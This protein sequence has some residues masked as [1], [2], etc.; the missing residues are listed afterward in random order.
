MH[1]AQKNDPHANPQEASSIYECKGPATIS[2]LTQKDLSKE[3]WDAVRRLQILDTNKNRRGLV[4]I[5]FWV[6]GGVLSN[7]TTNFALLAVSELSMGCALMGLSVF[8]HEASH[9]L[10]FP[11]PS[12]NR[13]VGFL[14]GLPALI[15]I[16][17]YRSLHLAHHAFE[18]TSMDPDD[19]EQ[20][21]KQSIP[22]AFFYYFFMVIGTYLYIPHVA[23]R[24]YVRARATLRINI[25]TEYAAIIV[26]IGM[27]LSFVP[28]AA[29]LRL[30]LIPLIIASQ[31]TNIRGIAEH[32]LTTGG[33]P[34]TASRTVLSNKVV[35]FFFCNLNYHLEH[36]LFPGVP[37]YNL[38]A[39]HA[40]LREEYKL[41]GSTVYRSYTEFFRDF[42]KTSQKG[43][44]PNVRL[45]P[46]H[47]REEICS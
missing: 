23:A 17:A 8:M 43:I 40:L 1:T 36:H 3:E 25:I 38:P 33:N 46:K 26:V 44:V 29:V 10:L 45:I 11:S 37:W 2:A 21:A 5:A 39:V 6:V 7:L 24:G 9:R 32:G 22:M 27:I 18:R 41:A 30:W 16:S 35:S 31:L 15:A 4:F 12:L 28:F 13:V 42:F 34:F 19:I 14:C 47:L 20:M